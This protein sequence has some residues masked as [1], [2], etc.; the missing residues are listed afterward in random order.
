[1]SIELTPELVDFIHSQSPWV[2][3][4]TLQDL[5]DSNR[6]STAQL[7]AAMRSL[8]DEINIPS[9]KR[10]SSKYAKTMR[11]LDYA[12]KKNDKILTSLSDS[13]DPLEAVA[14]LTGLNF[15]P[16]G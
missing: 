13:M 9:T 14:E 7:V 2:S 1:M 16:S 3:E 6:T 11:A 5:V 15:E 12:N 4:A 10:V 8:G